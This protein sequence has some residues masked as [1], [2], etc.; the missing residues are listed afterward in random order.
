MMNLKN[1]VMVVLVVGIMTSVGGLSAYA[2]HSTSSGTGSSTS[3]GAQP[4]ESGKHCK[5]GHHKNWKDSP[6]AKSTQAAF[7]K[8]K[9]V[10]GSKQ[11]WR[12]ECSGKIASYLN[13][14]DPSK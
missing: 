14:F 8:C 9:A 12:E 13:G 3:T 2:D 7:A 11:G 4:A 1:K 6:M 10:S 5:F